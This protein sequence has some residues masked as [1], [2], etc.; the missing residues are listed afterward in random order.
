MGDECNAMDSRRTK[1][2]RVTPHLQEVKGSTQSL[3]GTTRTTTPALYDWTECINIGSHQDELDLAV[4]EKLSAPLD[5]TATLVHK[6]W[7]PTWAKVVDDTDLLEFVKMAEMS[8]SRSH[9]IAKRLKVVGSEDVNK[10]RSENKTLHS[11][12]TL[13]DEA[14]AQAKYKLIKFET[15]QRMCINAWK[16]AEVKLKVCEDMS[17]TKHKELAE[18]LADL[19]K[20]NELL[21]KL[22]ASSCADPKE[23]MG[24]P[25]VS[26]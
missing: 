9:N 19:S 23:S 12:L 21:A 26:E 25:R 5:T 24:P 18:A 16:Q 10:L 22:G 14:R 6:Y 11:K 4:L 20:A 8:T 15:I 2:G 3:R 13:A 7:T 17:Y 1:R